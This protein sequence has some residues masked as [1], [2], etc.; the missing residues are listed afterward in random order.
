MKYKLIKEFT[1]FNLL[2]LNYDRVPQ[3][4]HVN[5]PNLSLD[6][7]DQ[8]R[9]NIRS[10]YVKLNNLLN[11]V[12][13]SQLRD[14]L[15]PMMTDFNLQSITIKN[16][17]LIDGCILKVYIIFKFDDDD[18]FGMIPN[19]LSPNPD[20]VSEIFNSKHIFLDRQSIIRL[21]GVIIKEIKKSLTPMRG[22]YK[23]LKDV[24]ALDFDSGNLVQINQ[25]T[26]VEVLKNLENRVLIQVGQDKLY[27]NDKA[28][29]FFNYWFDEVNTEI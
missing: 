23:A 12:I 28:Y 5:D 17:E 22:M 1:E 9:N 14:V 3:S 15:S 8:H 16:I 4:T 25:G 21:K 6:A 24:V 29:Y 27:L 13:Q 2:R 18:F 7:L 11:M 26:V 20:L 10:K 19:L